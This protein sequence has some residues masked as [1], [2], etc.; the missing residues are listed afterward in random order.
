MPR[1][2]DCQLEREMK[3]KFFREK[4]KIKSL[5]VAREIL[6]VIL[7]LDNFNKKTLRVLHLPF[8]PVCILSTEGL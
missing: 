5:S 2:D 8:E 7:F 6:Y 1:V 4:G 3:T